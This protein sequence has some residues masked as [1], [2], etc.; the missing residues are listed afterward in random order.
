MTNRAFSILSLAII[1]LSSVP[2]P[3]HA[4]QPPSIDTSARRVRMLPTPVPVHS[5]T[6][7]ALVSD[8]LFNQPDS[9]FGPARQVAES[10]GF[11]FGVR[12]VTHLAVA[13]SRYAA[14]YYLPSDVSRGYLIIIPGHRPDVVRGYVA[15]DSLRR[16]IIHYR[17]LVRPLTPGQ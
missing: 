1:G 12:A 13:D 9:T 16:R 14:V 3:G 5:P 11:S 17:Q 10:L 2:P 15:A 8:S 4:Q 7:F 6:I